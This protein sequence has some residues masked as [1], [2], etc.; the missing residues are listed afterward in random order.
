MS[1]NINANSHYGGSFGAFGGISLFGRSK[2]AQDKQER[3]QKAADQIAFWEG[4]KERL[5]GMESQTLE[6][7]AKKLEMYH[8]YEDEIMAA[9][10]AYNNEQMG[11]VL[12]EAIEWGEKIAEAV[13]KSRPKT[14]EERLEELAEEALGTE[15][16]EGMLEELTEELQELVEEM[17]KQ[18][19]Q[20]IQEQTSQELDEENPEQ[21]TVQDQIQANEETDMEA[22]ML[23]QIYRPI[24]IRI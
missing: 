4:Q 8:S 6:E 12:D 11:H 23:K 21:L 14:P 15:D 24:N 19:S 18:V 1:I 20:E 5:K 16:G 17:Q 2:S 9:K 10:M 22:E 13:E 7:I 3:Q